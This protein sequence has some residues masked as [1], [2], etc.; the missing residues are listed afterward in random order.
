MVEIEQFK[1]ARLVG[2]LILANNNLLAN[3]SIYW[4]KGLL[5]SES[6]QDNT[7]TDTNW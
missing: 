1:I 3:K 4:S 5:A 2:S 7:F 6:Q